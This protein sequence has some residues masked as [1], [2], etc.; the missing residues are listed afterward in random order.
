MEY[1][2]FHDFTKNNRRKEIF[3]KRTLF[4][5]TFDWTPHPKTDK[6]R[7]VWPSVKSFCLKISRVRTIDQSLTYP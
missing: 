3:N 7:N 5:T 6:Q 1:N 4:D 2:L